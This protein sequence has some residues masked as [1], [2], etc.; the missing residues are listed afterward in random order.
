VREAVGDTVGCGRIGD[1]GVGDAQVAVGM[2][3]PSHPR[4]SRVATV[5]P[6]VDASWGDRWHRALPE[7][8]GGPGGSQRPRRREGVANG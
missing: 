3:G 8:N 1:R 5:V 4:G 6:R 7:E 2:A